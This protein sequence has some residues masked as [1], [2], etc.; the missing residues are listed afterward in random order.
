MKNNYLVMIALITIM[1]FGAGCSTKT[2]LG[3]E[4]SNSCLKIRANIT[5]D[6]K[7]SKAVVTS[8]SNIT[9]GVYVDDTD[10]VYN[11]ETNS[12]AYIGTGTNSVTASPFIYINADA[13]VYAYY[14]ATAN[15]LT[16]PSNTST[17]SIELVHTD[18]F[19]ATA[20]TDY[21]WATPTSVSKSNSIANLTFQHA[22][23]KLVFSITKGDHYPGAGVLDSISLTSTGTPFLSGNGTMGIANGKFNGLTPTASLTF[24]GNTTISSTGSNIVALVAPTT[25]DENTTITL[26]IDGKSYTSN[27]PITSVTAWAAATTY[28]YNITIAE[29]ELEIEGVRTTDWVTVSETDLS[30]EVVPVPEVIETANCYMIAPGDRLKIPVNVRGNGVEVSGTGISASIDP[31][32]VGLLWETSPGL[33][34]LGNMSDDKK[35]TITTNNT[36]SGN[37]VI[38]AYSG[39]NQTGDILWSWHI[40]VTDYEPSTGATFTVTNSAGVSYVFMDRNLGATSSTPG[41]VGTLGLLYQWG[42]KDPFPGSASISANTEPTI[43]DSS[44]TGSTNM[45][46]KVSASS[47]SEVI[48]NPLTLYTSI[49]DWCTTPNDAFWGGSDISLSIPAEKTMFDP[50]PSGWR[51]PVWELSAS[52]WTAFSTSTFSWNATDLGRTY[53]DGSFYPAVGFR[54]NSSGTLYNVG[55]LGYCWS[56]SPHSGNGYCM[57]F[58]SSYVYPKPSLSRADGLSVRCVQE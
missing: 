48:K 3:D 16:N 42:R 50:C 17:K 33:V 6:D 37:A 32:S 7:S 44:G 25:L 9:I 21:L 41:E 13:N 30:V 55:S 27:F 22:L 52:P 5:D 12:T 39:E 57:Y 35:V 2:R 4:D 14:P 45:V 26:K 1:F 43:Y 8:P 56:G 34:S 49:S 53:T 54:G 40:W 38:A 19:A 46:E 51:V 20:Q 47:L 36:I 24:T 31:S 18:D 28:T 10:G 15:E 58:N 23:S 11:P 29:G